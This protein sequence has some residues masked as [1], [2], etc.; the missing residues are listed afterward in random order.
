MARSCPRRVGGIAFA[1]AVKISTDCVR[2]ALR[3][4]EVSCLILFR[5][6]STKLDIRVQMVGSISPPINGFQ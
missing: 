1:L 6:L 5:R 3:G 2:N 4:P